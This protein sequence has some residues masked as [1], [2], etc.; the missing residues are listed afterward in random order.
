MGENAL[1]M[2]WRVQDLEV[3]IDQRKPAETMW[4]KTVGPSS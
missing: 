1:V 2:K 4:K 3:E